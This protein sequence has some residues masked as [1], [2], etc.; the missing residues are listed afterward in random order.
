MAVSTDGETWTAVSGNA[1]K[2]AIR[3]IAYGNNRF[4]AVGNY[5][6]A[7]STDG[8]TWTAEIGLEYGIHY[9]VGYGDGKF[10][11][12][13]SVNHKIYYSEK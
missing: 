8:T 12:G 9:A 4:V 6:A 10:V 3:G 13:N 11:T 2:N 5:G 7:T 1:I